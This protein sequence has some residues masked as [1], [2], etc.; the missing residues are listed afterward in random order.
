MSID[1]K[2]IAQILAIMAAIGGFLLQHASTTKEARRA[3]R[4]IKDAESNVRE[5][6]EK[7]KPAWDL[8]R[9]TLEAYFNRNLVQVAA[10]FWLSVTVM[11][12][13]FAVTVWGLAQVLQEKDRLAIGLV[14][15]GA[16]L[17]TEF[18]GATF[19]FVYRSTMLQ[20][21]RYAVTLERINSVGM[22]VQILDTMPNTV[23]PN[24]LKTRTKARLVQQLVRLAPHE[25]ARN[26]VGDIDW[27]NMR[28]DKP[29][30]SVA[31]RRKR[32]SP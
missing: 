16:G 10:I 4:S 28:S 13:G 15:S 25:S 17:L 19:L 31:K 7:I 20:A 12:F 11:T 3:E 29:T 14:V 8:A 32:K 23:A 21:S 5:Q 24:D 26:D 1:Y 9:T 2:S 18:I 30:R 6:P 22:A 27:D